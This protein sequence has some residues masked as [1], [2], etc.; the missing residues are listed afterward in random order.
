MMDPDEPAL[1]STNVGRPP[2]HAPLAATLPSF[3]ERSTDDEVEPLRV[4]SA[5][6]APVGG[7]RQGQAAARSRKRLEVWRKREQVVWRRRQQVVW[8]KRQQVW[9]GRGSK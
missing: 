7:D 6:E 4:M 8:R 1:P 9:R 3:A 5:R 2:P